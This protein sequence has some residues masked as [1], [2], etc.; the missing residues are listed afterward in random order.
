[1]QKERT[2]VSLFRHMSLEQA[3]NFSWTQAISE[4]STKAPTLFSIMNNSVVMRA[5]SQ[6]N[7][8]KKL[9]KGDAQYP[10]L[11]AAVA[12]PFAPLRKK[13]SGSACAARQVKARAYWKIKFINVALTLCCHRVAVSRFSPRHGLVMLMTSLLTRYSKTMY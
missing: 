12:L 13:N 7:N 6:K 11:C 5:L 8:H 2:S 1:M 9:K 4:I 10:G 3:E